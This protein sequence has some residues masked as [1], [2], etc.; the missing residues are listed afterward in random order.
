MD[1]KNIKNW[2]DRTELLIGFNNLSKLNSYT[3][4]ILGL[5]GV[6][7]AAAES[8]CRAGIGN[9]IIIDNDLIDIT[10]INRQIISTHS[11]IGQSKA[12]EMYNRLKSINPTANI[13]VE[14]QFYLP[15]NSNFLF[16]YN[17]D[18][19]I[20]AIDTITSKIDLA[21]KC[22]ENKINF[23]SCMGMGNRLDPTQIKYGNIND[24]IG[25]GC[26]I[27]KIIRNKIKELNIPPINVIYSME[28]P[29]KCTINTGHKN[30]PG[31]LSCVPPV[32]GYILAS[33]VINHII[34]PTSQ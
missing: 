20:D 1:T 7:G 16:K 13:I 17:P 12:I 27:S 14:E 33:K 23:I 8:I 21:K 25:H 5:G 19:I 15:N 29:K 6:G 28:K 11:N 24:T 2:Y 10:N 18:Y 3:V 26:V 34:K 9:I 32:A 22:Y 30:S 4:A 31:S